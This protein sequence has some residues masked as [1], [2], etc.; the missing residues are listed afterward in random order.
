MVGSIG[1]L[2]LKTQSPKSEHFSTKDRRE[3]QQ[4]YYWISIKAECD[5]HHR[6]SLKEIAKTERNLTLLYSE[7]DAT[8][9]IHVFKI[10]LVIISYRGDWKYALEF[11]IRLLLKLGSAPPKKLEDWAF[12]LPW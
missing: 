4:L 10:D 11:G 6:P 9:Y 5:A 1:E 2:S 7:V 12:Y 3:S 8:H